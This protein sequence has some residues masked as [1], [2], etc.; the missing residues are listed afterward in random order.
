[1]SQETLWNRTRGTFEKIYHEGEKAAERMGESL[2][3]VGDSA[4]AR[5]EKLR[6][7]RQL[8]EHLAELGSAVYELDKAELQ[9]EDTAA[10]KT[11]RVVKDPDVRK[12]LDRIMQI[13][14]E[15]SEAESRIGARAS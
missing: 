8:F 7:E 14:Q 6:L 12:M 2:G 15:I 4:R 10:R 3:E 5:V 13:D 1:M 9:L 11:R